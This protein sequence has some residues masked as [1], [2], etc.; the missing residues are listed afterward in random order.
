MLKAA[1]VKVDDGGS[2]SSNSGSGSGS[3]AATSEVL[4]AFKEP[5]SPHLAAA[6]EGRVVDDDAV[7][8][9]TLASLQRFARRAAPGAAGDSRALCIV[10]TAGGVAS[11][12]PSGS[13]MVRCRCRGRTFFCNPGGREALALIM[14]QSRWRLPIPHPLTRTHFTTPP[15]THARALR[16]TRCARC[17]CRRC[18]SATPRS[19]A[20]PQR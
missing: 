3:G 15:H 6:L 12:A 2:A 18:S 14:Q 8:A 16:P 4:F 1:G 7:A 10:E 9:A 5:A 20:S 17:A 13:L 19:A 11:P